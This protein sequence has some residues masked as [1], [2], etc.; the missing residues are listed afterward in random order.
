MKM[1]FIKIGG[2]IQ[3][4]SEDGSTLEAMV[5]D[6]TDYTLDFSIP[7]DDK[8]FKLFHEGEQVEAVI[9]KDTKGTYFTGV[10]KGRAKGQVPTFTIGDLGN[11]K[12]IQRRNYVRAACTEDILYTANDYVINSVSFAT[13]LRRVTEEVGKYMKKGIMLDLSAGGIKL[14]CEEDIREG[15]KLIMEILLGNRS[16]LFRG[17]VMHRELSVKPTGTKYYYGV[18][19]DN[20]SERTQEMIMNHVFQLMRKSRQK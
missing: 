15:Q 19:F 16:H 13:D 7:V 4:T 1:D 14:T 17:T 3:I 20:V 5:A 8:R 11:L 9:F 10:I 12:T 6:K 2:K 18:R